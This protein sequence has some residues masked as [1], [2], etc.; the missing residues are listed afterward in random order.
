LSEV[1]ASCAKDHAVVG[2]QVVGAVIGR[3]AHAQ[4]WVVFLA[5]APHMRG[6]GIG[7]SLLAALESR[8]APQ[9]ITKLSALMPAAETR[10]DAFLNRGFELKQDLHYFERTIPV[11][12]EELKRLDE[13]GGRILPRGL[14]EAVGGMSAEKDLLERR[15][16]LPLAESVLA[17]RFGVVPPRAIVLFGPPGTGKTTFAKAIAL[18]EAA[19]CPPTTKS[20]GMIRR[21]ASVLPSGSGKRSATK[22]PLRRNTESSYSVPT[23]AL[24]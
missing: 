24:S 17:E 20:W 13:L 2:E 12:R 14:W 4:G 9:G 6:T 15:V 10:M 23:N 16:V 11:Q 3:V 18:I 22:S 19:A 7:S 21:A 1:L 8:M 5:T